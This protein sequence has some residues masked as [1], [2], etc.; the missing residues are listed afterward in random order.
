MVKYVAFAYICIYTDS[1]STIP[2]S[3]SKVCASKLFDR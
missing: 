3:A 1:T 2:V